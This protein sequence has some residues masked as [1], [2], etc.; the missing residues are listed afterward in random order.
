MNLFSWV[1]IKCRDNKINAVGFN[2]LT[3][4]FLDGFF[5]HQFSWRKCEG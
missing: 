2:Y 3:L 4:P 1:F 5:L